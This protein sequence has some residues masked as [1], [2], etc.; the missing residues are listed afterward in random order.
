MLYYDVNC[1]LTK[2]INS[3]FYRFFRIFSWNCFM[4]IWQ[5]GIGIRILIVFTK[6]HN[7]RIYI[8]QDRIRFRLR[9]FRAF[10]RWNYR[11]KRGFVTSR[12]PRQYNAVLFLRLFCK[13]INCFRIHYNTIFLWSPEIR[14]S[15]I[16]EMETFSNLHWYVVFVKMSYFTLI[17]TYY[18]RYYPLIFYAHRIA[19]FEN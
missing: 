18:A 17:Y 6:S 15:T 8:G 14:I 3:N 9:Q 7:F 11:W 13:K 10:N 4:E 16:L 19:T 12:F 1:H 5:N 2:K